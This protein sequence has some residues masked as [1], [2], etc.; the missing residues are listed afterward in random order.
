MS[1]DQKTVSKKRLIILLLLLCGCA[2][3]RNVAC[4]RFND[5]DSLMLNISAVND[6]I[7]MIEVVELFE[8]P[9]QLVANEDYFNDLKKQFDQSCHMEGN[10]LVRRYGLVLDQTYSLSK[11]IEALKKEKYS[12]E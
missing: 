3:Q 4:V 11:T 6:D 2:R 12:C 9:T 8:V 5:D 1:S 10:K 7:R